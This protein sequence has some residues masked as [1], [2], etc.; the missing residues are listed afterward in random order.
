MTHVNTQKHK[1]TEN[2]TKKTQLHTITDNKK[3][4]TKN[5]TQSKKTKP[6]NTQS[7]TIYHNHT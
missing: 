7:E 4:I 1:I 3:P 6:T 2:N 5:N